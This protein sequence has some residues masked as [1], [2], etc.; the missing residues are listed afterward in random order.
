MS[1]AGRPGSSV[2]VKEIGDPQS[3][4]LAEGFV[5]VYLIDKDLVRFVLEHVPSIEKVV[6]MD[7]LH[8]CIH[9]AP[10]RWK[11]RWRIAEKLLIIVFVPRNRLPDIIAPNAVRVA[12]GVDDREISVS[13]GDGGIPSPSGEAKAVV[14]WE[15]AKIPGR[16]AYPI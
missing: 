6:E 4:L 14:V 1:W 15:R 7:G 2:E 9:F 13:F 16:P 5:V 3:D 8:Q 10:Q 12:R 11:V